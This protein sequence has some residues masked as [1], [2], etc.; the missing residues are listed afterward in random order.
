MH[1]EMREISELKAKREGAIEMLQRKL[2]MH[3]T[4]SIRSS[5]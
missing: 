3:V 5:R 1:K 4:L 2:D